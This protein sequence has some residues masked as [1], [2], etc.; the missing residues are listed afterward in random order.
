MTT[1]ATN[2]SGHASDLER[3]ITVNEEI[4]HIV[5][6]SSEVRLAAMNAM[7]TAKR[8]GER[9]LGFAVV[10]SELRVFSRQ[11]DGFM[12]GLAGLISG[13][14]QR[15]AELLKQTRVLRALQMTMDQSDKAHELL[16]ALAQRKQEHI[17]RTRQG[18][19]HEWEMLS[20]QLERAQR[21]CGTGA[22]LSRSAKIEAAHGGDMAPTLRQVAEQIE[23]TVGSML[24]ILRS[25]TAQG[26]Q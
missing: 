13:L 3:A 17:Q 20:L 24:A 10:S 12:Q 7:L 23:E 15:V 19:M 21:A 9:S 25:L 8:A 18:I 4:K 1:T 2:S 11:L 14:I 22:A 5:A 26:H 16:A 6:T